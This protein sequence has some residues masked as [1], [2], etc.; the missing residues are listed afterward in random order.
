MA[1]EDE[2]KTPK[3]DVFSAGVVAV[4]LNTGRSPNP[5]PSMRKEG[6]RRVAVVEEERR[7]DDMATIRHPEISELAKRCIVD[8]ED[9]RADSAEAVRFCRDL[10]EQ[11]DNDL[12]EQRL[13]HQQECLKSEALAASV[14]SELAEAQREAESQPEALPQPQLSKKARKK[15]RAQENKRAAAAQAADRKA[16]SAK[17]RAEAEAEVQAESESQ[18]EVSQQPRPPPPQPTELSKKARKKKRARANKRATTAQAAGETSNVDDAPDARQDAN[19]ERIQTFGSRLQHICSDR[20]GPLQALIDLAIDVCEPPCGPK[21]PGGKPYSHNPCFYKIALITDEELRNGV[22]H[23]HGVFR[24]INNPAHRSDFRK[25]AAE[26]FPETKEAWEEQ[27]AAYVAAHSAGE[28][29][30]KTSALN[31]DLVQPSKLEHHG[32]VP[33]PMPEPESSTADST[34]TVGVGFVRIV[35]LKART[36]LNGVGGQ[37]MAWDAAAGRYEVVTLISGET[38]RVRP[39]NLKGL[40]RQTINIGELQDSLAEYNPNIAAR[41]VGSIRTLWSDEAWNATMAD[42]PLAVMACA[43]LAN[44]ISQQEDWHEARSTSQPELSKNAAR[45][46]ARMFIKLDGHCDIIEAM[47]RLGGMEQMQLVGNSS[48]MSLLDLCGDDWQPLFGNLR[49]QIG[50]TPWVEVFAES[51]LRFEGNTQ[52]VNVVCA[53]FNELAYNKDGHSDAAA[54]ALCEGSAVDAICG[55]MQM[56]RHDERVLANCCLVLKHLALSAQT[57]RPCANVICGACAELADELGPL[58]RGAQTS[59]PTQESISQVSMALLPLLDNASSA[60]DEASM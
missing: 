7:A 38:V 36:D 25:I 6:R 37:C 54:I 53:V 50:Q 15:K 42:Q 59:F 39:P 16:A 24:P 8:D 35:G 12:L 40:T 20:P 14:E 10:L 43:R 11:L 45:K 13:R 27:Q 58:L 31:G 22:R 56:Y 3:A 30:C 17:A 47:E 51:M 19:W 23:S 21:W 48:I 52:L 60:A 18:P 55:A 4:E 9:E 26:I 57:G 46:V 28:V 29:R 44:L 49:N 2:A 33:E 41:L 1:E 32:P 5:G 34:I